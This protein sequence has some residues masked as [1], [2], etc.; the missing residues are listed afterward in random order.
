M[1]AS[2]YPLGTRLNLP[3]FPISFDDGHV[4]LAVRPLPGDDLARALRAMGLTT[5]VPAI[6]LVSAGATGAQVDRLGP[7]IEK[8]LMPVTAEAGAVVVDEGQRGG[9]GARLGQACRKRNAGFPLIGVAPEHRAG[10]GAHAGLDPNHT[11]FVVVPADRPGW[12][13]TWTSA[14]TSALAGGNRSVALVTAGGEPAWESVAEHTRAGRLV[15]AVART[16]GVADH[17]AAAIRGATTDRRAAPL[18]ASGHV[19]VLD[20]AK[21]A[22]HVA[23]VLRRALGRPV[24]GDPEGGPARGRPEGRPAALGPAVVAPPPR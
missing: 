9:C 4:A 23:G 13:A 2:P 3:R 12:A 22:A 8:V 6:V 19:H 24:Q 5:G 21:G 11:H 10:D 18:V 20:P 1:P 14:V 15:M 17:L 7:L 16:G